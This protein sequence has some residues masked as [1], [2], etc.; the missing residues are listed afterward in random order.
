MVRE[1]LFAQGQKQ[2]IDCLS[3]DDDEYQKLAVETDHLRWDCFLE[4]RI[5]AQWIKIITTHLKTA[6]LFITPKTWGKQ[7]IE[8]LLSITHKQ[9][10]FRNSK[11]HLKKLDGLTEEEHHEVFDKM[12]EL[13]LTSKEELLPSHQHYLGE[14]FGKLS[15][16]SAAGRQ[17]WIANMESAISAFNRVQKGYAVPGSM[18]RFNKTRRISTR[19]VRKKSGTVYR[20]TCRVP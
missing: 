19:K 15:E 16:G 12:E 9:W 1:Y 18:P 17:Y 3:L 20:H 7:F 10:I 4:G 8:H 13:M 5:S 2:M 11:V 14:D 6:S